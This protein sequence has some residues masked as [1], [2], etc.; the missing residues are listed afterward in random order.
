MNGFI[1]LIVFIAM[2]VAAL[3]EDAQTIFITEMVALAVLGLVI[4]K[5]IR[6]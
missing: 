1:T 2:L 6:Q 4:R 5:E 3:T